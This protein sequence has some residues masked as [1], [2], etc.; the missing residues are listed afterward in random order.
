[1]NRSSDFLLPELSAIGDS[2][3]QT[4]RLGMDEELL[5]KAILQ[6]LQGQLKQGR[7]TSED[8]VRL[9]LFSDA[10]RVCGEAIEIDGT[11]SDDELS[12]ALPLAQAASKRLTIFRDFY[13]DL[14]EVSA[15]NLRE[16]LN[17]HRKDK[18]LF[19][20]AC[21]ET[22][23]L[24]L[25]IVRRVSQETSDR[26]ALDRYA[27]LMVRLSEEVLALDATAS[28]K[29]A[30]RQA[31]EKRLQLRKRLDEIQALAP[32]PTADPRIR[33]FC[34][35]EA[36]DVFHSVE[37]AQ[38]VFHRDPF[39]VELVHQSTRTLFER[40]VDRA[41]QQNASGSGR[42]L[43]VLGEAGSGKTHLMR[44]F[45]EI[46]HARRNGYVGYMQLSVAAD[47]YMRL[48]LMRLV[49]SLEKPYDEPETVQSGLLCLSDALLYASQ[50]AG[51]PAQLRNQELTD[52]E[53]IDL[54]FKMADRIV[55]EPAFRA[56]DLDLI[57]VILFL[58]RRLPHVHARALKYLRCE[59]MNAHD[60]ALLGDIS[61]QTDATNVTRQLTQLGAL[62]QLTGGGALVLLL[63]Q[64]EDMFNLERAGE[65]FIKAMSAVCHVVDHVP[66]A[67]LVIAGLR[68][69]YLQ[70]KPHLTRPLVD[71][72]ERDPEPQHL[73]FQRTHEE[74]EA[75]LE[76][77]LVYLY[78]SQGVRHR[79]DQPLFP[80]DRT[81]VSALAE[82]SA[83]EILA[84]VRTYQERCI[85]AGQLSQDPVDIATP[86]L[87]PPPAP[88]SLALEWETF[89]TSATVDV[90][91]GD[92]D[93]LALLNATL[94]AL[95]DELPEGAKL[96]SKHVEGE[97]RIDT[98]TSK[99][100]LVQVTNRGTRGGG[101]SRQLEALLLSSAKHKRIPVALRCSEFSTG[102]ALA[103]HAAAIAK[104][105]GFRLVFENG[106]WRAMLAYRQFCTEKQGH[107][108]LNAW[109]HEACTLSKLDSLRNL[110]GLS[111]GALTA[112]ESPPRASVP[113]PDSIALATTVAVPKPL[114]V[115]LA[116]V[117]VPAQVPA[118]DGALQ[119]GVTLS[120]RQQP[121]S[122]KQ[123]QLKK[124]AAFLGASG[125]G[126]TSLALNVI[127][128]LVERGVGA[129]LVDRKGDLASYADPQWWA[130]ADEKPERNQRKRA[131]AELAHV[132]LFTPGNPLGR[133]LGI[134]AVPEGLGT[135]P[136]HERAQLARF[137]AQGLGAMM[138]YGAK[139]TDQTYVGILTKAIEVLCQ[140]SGREL[141]LK[142]ITNLIAEEDE[143][144]IAELGHL[145]PR[146][147]RKVVDHLE[148]LRLNHSALLESNDEPLRPELLLGRD[149]SIPKGKVPIT[150]V[151]TKFLGDGQRVDFWLSQMLVS[152]SRWCSRNPSSQLQGVLFLDEADAY[153]PAT[154]K[155][156]TKEPLQDLLKRA[157][158]A[159]I[160]VMLAT[161]NPGDLDYKARDNIGTWWIG[162]IGSKTA[163]EKMKPLLSECRTDVSGSLATAS[164]GEFF[165]VTDGNV[166]R[167]RT[168]RSIM[169]TVQQSEDK[170]LELAALDV[171]RPRRAG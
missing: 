159:G 122:I 124:H 37:H 165:Q 112:Q 77:R 166:V 19:G 152:L 22:R 13:A 28:E 21:A 98:P 75:M 160:G 65:R 105:D 164:T 149:D 64:L 23:W 130:A 103:K 126:K 56:I 121:A 97:L 134:R 100:L 125:S 86:S 137:A 108:A 107:P 72:L 20:G 96:D 138:G 82:L 102:G 43:L 155:P 29:D 170:I 51:D 7:C 87:P 146:H 8:I 158:S 109:R 36:P 27:E 11:T 91:D 12:Y 47:D 94:L 88:S 104:R 5:G 162:R 79:P 143:S 35:R 49:E 69:F 32:E 115:E 127:E 95:K 26:D 147:L 80:L 30:R 136:A 68:D 41:G 16:F 140:S 71:R 50:R 6:R 171:A 83:R 60:R 81:F 145:E 55:G 3:C 118:N 106:D 46:V 101:L 123:E 167:M 34:S 128:Q 169:D 156:A 148:T 38:Q 135:L 93:L 57:R 89:R 168:D 114:A 76:R 163:I 84:S 142:D 141:G 39:D 161:Q 74:V 139:P 85:E 67:V 9:S 154:R 45:R 111:A 24:G 119:L 40:L 48:L 61:S 42:V 44:G 90:P 131:L 62:V 58:Q 133:S 52:G 54:V 132:R 73:S 33:A 10:L 99:A 150:V 151:S 17:A 70:L 78:E 25:E 153:L 63:D 66:N 110:L 129:V 113:T 14:G 15:E 59:P 53:A 116:P 4:L 18:Q 1:M 31:L 144:L 120:V 157:R 2:V 117:V 92:Q